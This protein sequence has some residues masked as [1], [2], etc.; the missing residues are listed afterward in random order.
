M[1]ISGRWCPRAVPTRLVRPNRP[2]TRRRHRSRACPAAPGWDN[3]D[4]DELLDMRVC[5]NQEDSG[6]RERAV[7]VTQG[8]RRT[9]LQETRNEGY[10]ASYCLPCRVAARSCGTIIVRSKRLYRKDCAE[11]VPLARATFT[12]QLLVAVRQ[13]FAGASPAMQLVTRSSTLGS[14]LLPCRVTRP[15]DRPHRPR[16]CR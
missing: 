13:G 4:E 14:R 3:D 8:D 12:F 5:R 11:L 2:S 15:L 6:W 1:P 16:S 9:G 10:Q 7:I